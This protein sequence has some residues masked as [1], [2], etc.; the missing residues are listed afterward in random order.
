MKLIVGLGNPG[1]RYKNTRHNVGF[2]ILDA[3]A[4]RMV[5]EKWSMVKKY[6]SSIINHQSSIIFVK[7]QTFMNNSGIAVKKL[8][9]YYKIDKSNLWVIHDDLDIKLGQYKIQFGK[10]PKEH[11]GL[12]SIYKELGTKDFWQVRVGVD[13][14][15]NEFSEKMSGEE[16][17][18]GNFDKNEIEI[19]DRVI[20][21]IVEEL[22]K[23]YA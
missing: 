5:N 7:P 23:D 17:V 15:D 20:A 8:M 1:E 21:K 13:N 3:L 22:K 16:Y 2:M 4:S 10:G 14:R 6:N 9:D 18:L 19:R 12:L 11:G